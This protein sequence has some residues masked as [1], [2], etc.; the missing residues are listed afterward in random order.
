MT[1]AT[2]HA[3]PGGKTPAAV[4]RVLSGD[5]RWAMLRA[6]CT[7]TLQLIPDGCVDAVITDPPYGIGYKAWRVKTEILNDDGPFVWWLRDAMRVLR[8]GGA[9]V[10]FTRWDVQEAFRLAIGWAG[11]RVRSQVVWDKGVHS[12]GDCDTQFGARHEVAWF[13]VKQRGFKFYNGRPQSVIHTMRPS[14]RGRTHP[15]EKPVGLLRTLVRHTTPAG[16]VVL[17]GFAGSGSTGEAA[18]LEGRRFIGLE[19]DATH[20]KGASARLSKV[21]A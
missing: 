3:I 21:G 1:T 15:T 17:D 6:D 9:L 20:A 4:A 5:S 12:M 8:P 11:L 18:L 7:R 2:R 10:C 19:I 13:A 16:G 14:W